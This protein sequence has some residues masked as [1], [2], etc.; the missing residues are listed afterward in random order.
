MDLTWTNSPTLTESHISTFPK[1]HRT[2]PMILN[3]PLCGNSLLDFHFRGFSLLEAVNGSLHGK[4]NRGESSLLDCKSE[5][6]FRIAWNFQTNI[7]YSL[8]LEEDI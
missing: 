4:H 1:K 8:R 5:M 3:E 2:F 6:I 7:K